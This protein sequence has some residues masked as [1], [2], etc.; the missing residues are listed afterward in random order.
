M[1][2]EHDNPR[3]SLGKEF[4]ITSAGER[5]FGPQL[6][7]S[8]LTPRLRRSEA[9]EVRRTNQMPTAA[10]QKLP[11][12]TRVMEFG[13]HRGTTVCGEASPGL[14]EFPMYVRESDEEQRETDVIT[15]QPESTRAQTNSGTCRAVTKLAL[16]SQR[17]DGEVQKISGVVPRGSSFHSAA[18]KVHVK[19][20]YQE[21]ADM[22]LVN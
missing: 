10:H 9:N 11:R 4:S 1:E 5:L 19:N 20:T 13:T 15:A 18:M 7:G 2:T 16:I 22:I 14:Q 12:S 8:W 17:F 21:V 6:E 3:S